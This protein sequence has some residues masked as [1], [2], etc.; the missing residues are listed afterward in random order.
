[1][2]RSFFPKKYMLFLCPCNYCVYYPIV[3]SQYSKFW[4]LERWHWKRVKWH[5]IYQAMSL[6]HK[7]EYVSN[8]ENLVLIMTHII[9]LY[10]WVVSVAIWTNLKLFWSQAACML[11]SLLLVVRPFIGPSDTLDMLTLYTE[12][13]QQA[14][15]KMGG[16]RKSMRK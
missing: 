4:S 9:I 12:C 5:I 6:I 14:E 1:M 15:K 2:L 8:E 3:Q 7:K 11:L 13:C 16:P 10:G